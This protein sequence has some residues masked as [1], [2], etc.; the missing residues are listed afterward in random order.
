MGDGSRRKATEHPLYPLLHDAPNDEQTAYEWRESLLANTLVHGNGYSET[1]RNGGGDVTAI[2]WVN[3]ARMTPMRVGGVIVY[4]F[5]GDGPRVRVTADQILHLRGP[6]KDGLVGM[7]VVQ[8]HREAIGLGLASE[9]FGAKFLSQGTHLKNTF[10]H[11][12]TLSEPAFAR[13][14][15]QLS[16][17]RG[18]DRAHRAL[19]L[20]EGMDVKEL[21]MP[22]KDAQFLESR[23]F[24]IREIARIFR[25]PPH[26]LAEMTRATFSNIEEQSLEFVVHCIRPWAVRMEQSFKRQLL[27]RRQ[28]GRFYIEHNL[29]GLLRGDFKSRMEGYAIARQWGLMSA[30]QVAALENWPPV[31]GG[32]LCLV[33][34]NMVPADK[35]T[36]IVDARIA[37]KATVNTRALAEETAIGIAKRVASELADGASAESICAGVWLEARLRAYSRTMRLDHPAIVDDVRAAIGQAIEGG[38]TDSEAMAVAISDVLEGSRQLALAALKTGGFN[39]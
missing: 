38:V 1:P 29:D 36:E 12:K 22:L 6:S 9:K 28:W 14:K 7:S 8:T 15:K 27:P 26:M 19:I 30:D 16:D 32:D 24:Q 33:P 35:L 25:I 4:D 18:L 10:T 17:R 37:A 34:L 31:P 39:A 20:E 21:T 11:P 23:E 2:H 13:L 5:M 3:P